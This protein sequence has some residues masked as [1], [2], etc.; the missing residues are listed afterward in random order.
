LQRE[1]EQA[2]KTNANIFFDMDIAETYDKGHGRIEE[3]SC[4]IIRD[5]GKIT[6]CDEW[7]GLKSIVE[8]Q[9]KVTEKG[10]VRESCNYYISSSLQSA[11]SML[12]S[13][14]AHWGVES[15][16]WSLDVVFKEDASGIRKD[17]SPANI[18]TVRRFVF[19]ILNIIKEK[20]R[21]KPSMM[22]AIGWSP[23]YL[24]RFINQLI[25]CS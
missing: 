21:S 22:M 15:M 3:R 18:A 9:R 11:T 25:D 20:G 23:E 12:K 1:V 2:F 5:L 10:Q 17:H 7:I 6:I 19:N 8:V 13:I 14:R 24:K 16:H 4:R